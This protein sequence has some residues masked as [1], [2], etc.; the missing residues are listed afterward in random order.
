MAS[1]REIDRLQ[2]PDPTS[3]SPPVDVGTAGSL[4]GSQAL[5]ADSTQVAE[6]TFR[7]PGSDSRDPMLP[8]AVGRRETGV[9]VFA[10]PSPATELGMLAIFVGTGVLVTRSVDYGGFATPVVLGVTI[11]L[12]LATEIFHEGLH[13]TA[14]RS[15]GHPAAVRWLQLAV[16]PTGAAVPRRDLLVAVAT[17]A[18]VVSTVA[19]VV[20]VFASRPIVV[21]AAGY[22]LVV[23]A[24]LSVVDV[25]TAIELARHPAGTVVSFDAPD[26]GAR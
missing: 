6:R 15:S 24:T 21:A 11:G 10:T 18:V 14:L 26:D 22:V 20:A 7:A 23:N 1:S 16:V 9:T 19:A 8:E 4:D 3:P 13:L 2:S 25:A 17:P 5:S 12:T